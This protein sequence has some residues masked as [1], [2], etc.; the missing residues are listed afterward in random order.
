M[1]LN[2]RAMLKVSSVLTQIGGSKY[3]WQ[4]SL[5]NCNIEIM[6]SHTPS[7]KE[8]C[9]SSLE[10]SNLLRCFC[11]IFTRS[12]ERSEDSDGEVLTAH[13]DSDTEGSQL[14]PCI[15]DV[16]L[17]RDVEKISVFL[18]GF[19]SDGPR[20]RPMLEQCGIEASSDLVIQVLSKFRND[21]AAAFTF[22]LWA[23][24]QPGYTHSI[25][26]YHTM[27]SILGKMR[28]FDTAWALVDEMR[29]RH[30]GTSMSMVT[31]QTLLIMVRKYCAAHDVGNAIN[32]FYT[33]KKF[34]FEVGI[35]EFQDL[36]SA[37]CRYKNVEDAE[38]LLYSNKDTFPFET[39]SFNIILNGWGN[40]VGNLR[41]AKRTWRDMCNKG[42]PQDAF[43]YNSMISCYSRA[44]NL[45]DA[46][47]LFNQM[48]DLGVDPDRKVY[49]AMAFALAKGNCTREA[50]HLVKTMEEKGFSPDAVTYN[51]LIKPLCKARKMQ[52]ARAVF[53]AML[54]KRFSPSFRTFHAFFRALRSEEEVFDLLDTMKR[55]GCS[56]TTD[57]Y[58]MLIRK[59]CRWRQHE[60]VFKIWNEMGTNG[61]CPDRSSYIVLTHGLFLNGRVDD[62]F[63]YYEEMKTKGFEPE[64]KTDE[65]FGAWASSKET[66]PPRVLELKSTT[67]GK[68]S[69][70]RLCRDFL[71][72]PEARR[73]T[74]EKGFRFPE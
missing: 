23:G 27:I 63:K 24:K 35:N 32:T 21:W 61:P 17:M 3:K 13:S 49:N 26:A 28:R 43:S 31:P 67:H 14:E 52:D 73:F 72:Q 45:N 25:R 74:R 15:Q 29:G 68:N 36:L 22:F 57:T 64:P 40:I 55:M 56:P 4:P 53:D 62:A 1:T 6:T 11:T 71:K 48:K 44:G 38:H 20:A 8:R 51:S 58:I 10:G 69:Y 70:G 39:K 50:I 7:F 41:E 12:L 46:L 16:A 2:R 34:K 30:S 33:F 65:M 59:F 19:G 5:N 9:R 60:N 37:L 54:Q 47:K 42:I 66:V 18:C